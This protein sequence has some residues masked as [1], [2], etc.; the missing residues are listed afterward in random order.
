M[1]H[2]LYDFLVSAMD[3]ISMAVMITSDVV[4]TLN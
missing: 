1:S 3:H 2:N 4:A